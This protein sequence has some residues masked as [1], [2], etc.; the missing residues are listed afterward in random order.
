[1]KNNNSKLGLITVCSIIV[2][3]LAVAVFVLVYGSTQ[4]PKED[5]G[6][7]ESHTTT[8]NPET[9]T[10]EP[11]KADDDWRLILVNRWN[12]LP[13]DFTVD[14]TEYTKGK[15]LDSRIIPELDEMF[16]AARSE[17]V[18][19]TVRSGYRSSDEQYSLYVERR[20]WLLDDGMSEADADAEIL[21]WVSYP[22]TSEHQTGLSLDVNGD[23]GSTSNEDG[24]EWLTTNAYKYGFIC[25]YPE[26]KSEITGVTSEPWH[27]RYVGKDV[28]E[29]IY[30]GNLT[31]E[32]YLGRAEH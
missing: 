20:Q 9:E 14:L 24:Y 2:L 21:R 28:A 17:G 31:L 18:N 29:I 15:Y 10:A 7:T 6:I 5:N 22:G 19:I 27:I 4:A 16:S 11:E 12:K 25:R 3:I 32:E 13:E 8:Q 26:D 23:G 30:N 1:M